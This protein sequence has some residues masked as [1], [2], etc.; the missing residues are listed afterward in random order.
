[1]LSE[2]NGCMTHLHLG[3]CAMLVEKFLWDSMRRLSLL[4]LRVGAGGAG[5]GACGTLNRSSHLALGG[6]AAHALHRK[7]SPGNSGHERPAGDEHIPASFLPEVPL[8]SSTTPPK[9]L[10]LIESGRPSS[11]QTLLDVWGV[12]ES[13]TVQ[14]ETIHRPAPAPP[15][16]PEGSGDRLLVPLAVGI[17]GGV[18]LPHHSP[19]ASGVAREC[20]R[21][22]KGKPTPK[23]PSR[24]D[25]PTPA[26]CEA[27]GSCS[28]P[29][30]H[31]ILSRN[32]PAETALESS[33]AQ[34]D[35]GE[36]CGPGHTA[37]PAFFQ[38]AAP[39]TRPRGTL[40]SP[41]HLVGHTVR[42]AR[43]VCLGVCTHVPQSLPTA[44]APE[45]AA[46]S[47]SSSWSL[48]PSRWNKGRCQRS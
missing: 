20:R 24:E 15:C 47:C 5:A 46:A 12:L 34:H 42:A 23:V 45:M 43:R 39:A 4:G 40:S 7:W 3:T 14:K 33:A 21:E 44:T 10:P 38:E 17:L 29:V 25:S 26:K 48:G 27:L 13:R 36:H 22:K 35:P 37:G 16:P 28:N 2:R 11:P 9:D 19:E 6:S 1:M 30:T 31:P 18:S 32:V 8:P 41:E